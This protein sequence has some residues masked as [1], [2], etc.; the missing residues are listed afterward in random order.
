[1]KNNFLILM[2][3]VFFNSCSDGGVETISKPLGPEVSALHADINQLEVG[4]ADSLFMTNST[5]DEVALIKTYLTQARILTTRLNS[6]PND[7]M[8]A[9]ELFLVLKKIEGFPFSARDEG[10]FEN[11]VFRLR[12][13]LSKF[14]D[15]QNLDLAGIEWSLLKFGFQG[16]LSPFKAIK[17]FNESPIWQYGTFKADTYAKAESRGVKAN[18][19]LFSPIYD[20]KGSK[21]HQLLVKHIVRNPEWENFKLKISTDYDGADPEAATW[22]ELV[23]KPSRGVSPNQWTTLVTNPIDLSA[24]TGKKVIF[25]FQFLATEK[26]NSVWE[27]LNLEIK[28][29][30]NSISSEELQVT[31]EPAPSDPPANEEENN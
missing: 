15:I 20:L 10:L 14:A 27:I 19:W 24:Y 12:I 3:L 23:V 21:K 2:I 5:K 1:M 6:I 18:A 29:T 7:G 30:G 8:A 13:T 26:S 11:M 28:G 17:L 22:T 16:K 25:A 31:Y 4:L 9:K